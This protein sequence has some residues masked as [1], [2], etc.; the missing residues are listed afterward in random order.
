MAVEHW[1][2]IWSHT[3]T[4]VHI[5][6]DPAAGTHLAREQQGLKTGQCCPRCHGGKSFW[7]L[8]LQIMTNLGSKWPWWDEQ[9]WRAF[10]LLT[11]FAALPSSRCVRKAELQQ[12]DL[13]KGWKN[14][15]FPYSCW[16]CPGRGLSAPLTLNLNPL[17][18]AKQNRN[19]QSQWWISANFGVL[20]MPEKVFRVTYFSL[21]SFF[22]KLL[23]GYQ[24]FTWPSPAGLSFSQ[25]LCRV[26]RKMR[27]V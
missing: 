22:I 10:P 1:S 25:R 6:G 18:M 20:S 3:R 9:L 27:G 7:K 24:I 5:W 21:E 26:A 14:M 12:D 23:S 4:R 2:V 11:Y 8:S 17:E 15:G 13:G 16:R 19:Q